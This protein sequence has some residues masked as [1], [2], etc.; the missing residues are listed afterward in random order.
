[1][2]KYRMSVI[3]PVYNCEDYIEKCVESLKKQTM[4]TAHFQIIL[5]NDGSTD[6][7]GAICEAVAKRNENT[8]YIYPRKT[9]GFPLHAM[10]A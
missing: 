9:E 5:V 2:F 4:P 3:V 7:S 10:R 8:I 1:M 6:N